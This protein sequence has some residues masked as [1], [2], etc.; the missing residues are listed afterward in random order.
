MVNDS[1]NMYW[2]EGRVDQ[3]KFIGWVAVQFGENYG[4]ED[5]EWGW[6]EERSSGV[7]PVLRPDGNSFEVT[8]IKF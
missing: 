2:V 5:V 6:A 7:V 1:G 4:I 8:C 3:Y